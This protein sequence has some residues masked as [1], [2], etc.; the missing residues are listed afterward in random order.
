MNQINR[1]LAALLWILG[2]LVVAGI[3]HIIAIFAMPATRGRK[4]FMRAFWI[5]RNRA[6]LPSCRRR[7][8]A[9]NSCLFAD[10]ALAQAVCPFDLSQGSLR[11]H[12][13]VEADKLLT[14]SFRN[15]TGQVFYSMSGLAAQQGKIE[16]VLLTPAQ[17]E[18]VE[19]DDD[20]DNPS[21]DL[22]LI[23]PDTKGFVIVSR[24]PPFLAKRRTQRCASRRS[25]AR[26]SKSLRIETRQRRPAAWR[27]RYARGLSRPP[28]LV[29]DRLPE[30]RR[31]R[32]DGCLTLAGRSR[33]TPVKT[34]I[35][36]AAPPGAAEAIVEH[37][38]FTGLK[39]MSSPIGFFPGEYS[40]Q[41]SQTTNPSRVPQ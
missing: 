25:L 18:I 31:P 12:A 20:E 1:L 5:W 37:S 13:D 16:V 34:K 24:L 33:Q 23:A 35:S 32:F 17:L 22:R 39:A 29:L 36:A 7:G 14:L 3:T 9:P 10:P 27:L 15:S 41:S 2:V 38:F 40:C 26:S 11:L 8:L 19:A 28:S 30:T 6:K 4:I 21:Q